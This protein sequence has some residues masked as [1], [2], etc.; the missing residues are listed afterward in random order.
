MYTTTDEHGILN[1]FASETK[2]YL[3]E[4]PSPGQQRR[5]WL[6]GGAALLLVGGLLAITVVVS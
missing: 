6:Q 3:A 4:Q 5:Y 2:P 1:N